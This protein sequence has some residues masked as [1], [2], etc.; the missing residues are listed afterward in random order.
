MLETN[1]KKKGEIRLDKLIV[2]D[3]TDKKV[4]TN[5]NSLS[6]KKFDHIKIAYLLNHY[7]ELSA[8][9]INFYLSKIFKLTWTNSHRVSALLNSRGHIFEIIE[10]YPSIKTYDFNGLIILNKTTRLNWKRK[11]DNFQKIN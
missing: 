10:D 4:F 2:L 11:L 7:G 9:Q 3:T 8:N 5:S 1:Q 6:S